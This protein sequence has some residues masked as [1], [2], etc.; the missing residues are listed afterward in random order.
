LFELR[1]DRREADGGRLAGK[2]LADVERGLAVARFFPREEL[3]E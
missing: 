1:L 3:I 2:I